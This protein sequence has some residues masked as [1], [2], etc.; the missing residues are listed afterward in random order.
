MNWIITAGVIIAAAI[1]TLGVLFWKNQKIK[2]LLDSTGPLS[3]AKISFKLATLLCFVFILQEGFLTQLDTL[4]RS[5]NPTRNISVFLLIWCLTLASTILVSFIHI[6]L[7]RV[8]WGGFFAISILAY[9]TFLQIMGYPPSLGDA[10]ILWIETGQAMAAFMFYWSEL[11]LPLIFSL[12][13]FVA[14]VLPVRP[15]KPIKKYWILLP[16]T[17]LPLLPLMMIAG[18]LAIK[19]GGAGV[20]IPGGMFA[21]SSYAASIMYETSKQPNIKREA[22]PYPPPQE[23]MIKNIILVVDESISSDFISLSPGATITPIL[24][25]NRDIIADFGQATS[26]HNCSS[27]SN[28]ILRWGINPRSLLSAEKLPTIWQ[29]AKAAGFKTTY[30]DAQKHPGTYGNLM[31]L[32]ETE[33]IDN[34][35]QFNSPQIE[36][37]INYISNDFEAIKTVIRLTSETIPNFIYINKLGVHFPYEGKYPENFS[38]HKPHM[39]LFEPLGNS[40][41]E[42]LINSYKNAISWNIDG[43]FKPLI[44]SGQLQNTVVIYTSDHGQNLLDQGTATHCNRSNS[45]PYQALV[46]LLIMTRDKIL[47]DTFKKASITNKNAVS[48][49]NIFPTILTLMGYPAG[50][51]EK[52]YT[53]TLFSPIQRLGKFSTGNLLAPNI[54]KRNF[55]WEDIPNELESRM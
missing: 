38:E 9:L 3:L 24:A 10:K 25:N 45:S 43:F 5:E 18:M 48:H 22:V 33:A 2:A 27:F 34:I 6:A 44:N 37:D 41:R 39:S 42:Q 21:L 40:T 20:G 50:L 14:F 23:S 16:V 12:L 8:F 30:I 11:I 53:K 47:L 31:D 51:V 55:G 19:G 52:D 35:I 1:I 4:S 28:A 36:R 26:G 15:I 54:N 49:F 46:P 29:Y 7:I 13:F 32:R 17:T